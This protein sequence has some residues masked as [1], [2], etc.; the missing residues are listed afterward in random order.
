MQTRLLF[1]CCWLTPTTSVHLQRKPLKSSQLPGKCEAPT[2]QQ[3]TYSD[4]LY[5]PTQNLSLDIYLPTCDNASK[6]LLPAMLFVH[7]GGWIAGQKEFSDEAYSRLSHLLAAGIAIVSI[8]YR[9]APELDDELLLSNR[10]GALSRSNMDM[11]PQ[12]TW[13]AQGDDVSDAWI[14]LQEHAATYG[15][16]TERIGCW[17]ESAGAHLCQ[18]LATKGSKDLSRRPQVVASMYG[19]SCFLC[20]NWTSEFTSDDPS[21][22]WLFGFSEGRLKELHDLESKGVTSSDLLLVRSAEPLEWVD[23]NVPPMVLAHGTND[24]TVTYEKSQWMAYALDGLGVDNK[25]ILVENGDH[26]YG[27]WA[28]LDTVLIEVVDWILVYLKP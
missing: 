9:L 15:I 18:W 1:L 22:D 25:L 7:W 12:G 3:A 17:G 21:S 19:I 13:P 14:W 26:C 11:L 27:D 28:D 5:S 24:T 16:N 4:L 23:E 20:R 2:T 10:H 8:D 6:N